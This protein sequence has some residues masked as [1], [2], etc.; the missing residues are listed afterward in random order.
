M[1]VIVKN[2]IEY[3]KPI[4]FETD[5]E[6]NIFSRNPIQNRIVTKA[7][8]GKVSK[9]SPIFIGSLSLGRN[10]AAGLNSIAVGNS[11]RASGSYSQSFGNASIASG[12]YSHAEGNQS[13][14]TGASSHA[15][16]VNTLASGTGSHASG[17]GTKASQE[18]KMAI[19]KYNTDEEN[20]IFE[21]GIGTSDTNR[22]NAMIVNKD[23]II[24]AKTDV[25][26]ENGNSIS[27][28]SEDIVNI[29]GDIE[30]LRIKITEITASIEEINEDITKIKSQI[31]GFT[32]SLI[33]G[34]PCLI[35]D[36]GL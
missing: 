12:N 2:K 33:D 20:A 1:G 27:K 22:S 16:G 9:D 35:Y 6:L 25:K 4:E 34:I 28:C 7:L 30:K 32:F 13:K 17:I 8:E 5:E 11:V 15:E 10:G 21:I 29:E 19:G 31:N 14:A 36:D 3:G 24:I 18:G 26:L 23:G